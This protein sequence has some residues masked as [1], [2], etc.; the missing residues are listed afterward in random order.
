MNIVNL[1]TKQ[2]K[3]YAAPYQPIIMSALVFGLTLW[4]SACSTSKSSSN[5]Q[6]AA[7]ETIFE[8]SRKITNLSEADL[9]AEK[10]TFEAE[11][12]VAANA[13]SAVK[14]ALILSWGESSSAEDEALATKLLEALVS[15]PQAPPM[16]I[17]Y[18]N[19]VAQWLELLQHRL[20][21]RETLLVHKLTVDALNQLQD[22]YEQLHERNVTLEKAMAKLEQHN[23]QLSKQYLRMQQQIEA[24]TVIE[25]QLAER[26][27]T[28]GQQ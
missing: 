21:V 14:L 15:D 17:D 9:A 13:V 27:Q 6:S 10:K 16:T 19:F 8:Y 1:T 26:E 24:L 12:L 3:N 28:Q 4:L 7:A 22:V 20:T 18:Q 23:A 2:L 5:T 25:Q 11:L